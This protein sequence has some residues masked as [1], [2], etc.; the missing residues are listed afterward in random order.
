MSDAT[1]TDRIDRFIPDGLC[2]DPQGTH[3]LS[4]VEWRGK[5][6]HKH[7]ATRR[8]VHP[9]PR[10]VAGAGGPQ[11]DVDRAGGGVQDD[12]AGGGRLEDVDGGGGHGGARRMRGLV[13]QCGARAKQAGGANV[14]IWALLAGD[15]LDPSASCGAVTPDFVERRA[16]KTPAQQPDVQASS[17]FH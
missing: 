4:S 5:V 8:R 3:A 15:A 11:L 13:N 16:E 12:L 2:G 6:E 10:G 17:F 14:A 7:A 1:Q 9:L